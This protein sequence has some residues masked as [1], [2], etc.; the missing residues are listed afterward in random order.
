MGGTG[1]VKMDLV[2]KNGNVE[3]WVVDFLE[4]I[5]KENREEEEDNA[6]QKQ[7]TA[8]L[9]L[10]EQAESSQEVCGRL[11]DDPE[12]DEEEDEEETLQ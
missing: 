4:R 3:P 8:R 12:E 6:I 10:R 2:D 9:S 1:G 11:F 5:R 7:K